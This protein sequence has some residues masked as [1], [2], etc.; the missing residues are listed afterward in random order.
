MK[1]RKKGSLTAEATIVLPVVIFVIMIVIRLCILHYQNAVISAEA[2]GVA[3]RTA[4]HWQSLGVDNP[5]VFRETDTA[6]GWITDGSFLDHNPYQSLVELFNGSGDV[7]KKLNNATIYAARMMNKTP[8]LLGEDTA[9]TGVEVQRQ[10][11]L[12]QNY[13]VVTVTRKNE[14]PLG[15]LYEKLG[16]TAPDEQRVTA[17]GIQQD[18][19]EFMRMFSLLYD[20][21]QG[22]FSEE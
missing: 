20:M 11:G 19:T 18:T 1:H 17:K 4:I 7:Q 2:M 10:Y 14:N 21:L 13:I 15:Y 12:L 9:V 22:E 6:R 3:S 16:L 5:A 8:N